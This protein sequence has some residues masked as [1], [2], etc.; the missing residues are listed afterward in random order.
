MVYIADK[1]IKDHRKK[2]LLKKCKKKI[3]ENKR[4][5]IKTKILEKRKNS[6]QKIPST[7]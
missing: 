6:R 4:I 7:K 3:E 5:K 2:S 1:R